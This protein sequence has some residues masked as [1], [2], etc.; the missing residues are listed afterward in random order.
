MRGGH[1]L[2][3]PLPQAGRA[4]SGG[5]RPLRGPPLAPPLTSG[6]AVARPAA[7][8]LR[9]LYANAGVGLL[10]VALRERPP[11]SRLG[12][13]TRERPLRTTIERRS[14][15]RG[16]SRGIA[17]V[18]VV[19]DTGGPPRFGTPVHRIGSRQVSRWSKRGTVI[20]RRGST[21]FESSDSSLPDTGLAAPGLSNNGRSVRPSVADRSGGPRRPTADARALRTPRR[22]A[23]AFPER[24]CGARRRQRQRRARASRR[25]Q[26]ARRRD[27][28][29]S[30]E[31]A[32][33]APRATLWRGGGRLELERG[34]PA[35]GTGARRECPRRITA[36]TA[37]TPLV[38][39]VEHHVE[40]AALDAARQRAVGPADAVAFCDR[41]LQAQQLRQAVLEQ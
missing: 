17:A 35:C 36:S 22:A 24:D 26:V 5:S 30:G 9:V 32:A 29:R 41:A 34:L 40:P 15:S 14:S 38:P 31:A 37:T 19:R 12:V 33:A 16:Y 13:L 27:R 2:R 18:V 25:R 11:R 7:T 3:A 1:S 4:R 39:V 6:R 21:H 20:G 8:S 10:Q 23:R 28:F